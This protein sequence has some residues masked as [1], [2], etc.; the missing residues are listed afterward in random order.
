M[1]S[2]QGHCFLQL[3]VRVLWQKLNPG[4]AQPRL[5]QHRLYTTQNL[6][7]SFLCDIQNKVL[8]SIVFLKSQTLKT[9][10]LL[11]ETN[12]NIQAK[13]STWFKRNQKTWRSRV[14]RRL[15]FSINNWR[16]CSSDKVMAMQVWECESD[17]SKHKSTLP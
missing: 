15:E 14:G 5:G 9:W 7:S 12:E 6:T 10:G 3:V 16:H 4:A 1:E 11:M 13:E 8:L 17:Y 2:C